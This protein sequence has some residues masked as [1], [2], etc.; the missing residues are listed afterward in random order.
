M[1]SRTAPVTIVAVLVASLAGCAAAPTE[2]SG[3]TPAFSSEAEAFAA[4]EETYRAYVDALNQVDLSD[5][6]TFEDVY[7]WTTG[8]ANADER[9]NF[10]Q[11]HGD[12]WVVS[13]ES[14][15]TVVEA[16]SLGGTNERT[17]EIA[18]CLDVSDV[19]LVDSEG[20]SVVDADR[21]AV[22]SMLVTLAS[23]PTTSTTWVIASITGR[24]GAPR[25]D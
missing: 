15:A 3:P 18:V 5:P 25:C 2:P 17:L 4:A 14:R 9:K 11:M 24:D 13:G 6:E 23:S 7:A 22:Q 8:E 10:S 12:G 21:P 20:Q 1:T 19:E 16:R